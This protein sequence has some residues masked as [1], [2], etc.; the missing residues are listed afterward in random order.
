MLSKEAFPRWELLTLIFFNLYIFENL[1]RSLLYVTF[2]SIVLSLWIWFITSSWEIF[3]IILHSCIF[4]RFTR[5]SWDCLVACWWQ[6]LFYF[7]YFL[8]LLGGFC[9]NSNRLITHLRS[10]PLRS[11]T[12]PLAWSCWFYNNFAHWFILLTRFYSFLLFKRHWFFELFKL[13]SL[14][15]WKNVV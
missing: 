6:N 4:Y 9:H 12:L 3:F 1:L 7:R 5:C 8:C 11:C 13:Y 15:W 14:R 10:W 2:E